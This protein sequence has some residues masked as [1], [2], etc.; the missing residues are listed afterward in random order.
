MQVQSEVK[1]GG[2]NFMR[3]EG[4]SQEGG[5]VASV[6]FKI[7]VE[8]WAGRSGEEWPTEEGEAAAGARRGQG[9]R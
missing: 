9:G 4:W 3:D 5:Q 7:A 2:G 8:A 1:S 6:T